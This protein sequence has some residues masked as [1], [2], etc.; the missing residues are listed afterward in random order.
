VG[1]DATSRF[2]YLKRSSDGRKVWITRFS[3][4]KV[5]GL[6]LVVVLSFA[7]KEGDSMFW[8]AGGWNY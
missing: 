5:G 1:S 8:L 2:F 3:V 4:N 7:V 6:V